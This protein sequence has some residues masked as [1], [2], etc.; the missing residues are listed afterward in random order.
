MEK[1]F[2]EQ[3]KSEKVNK[4]KDTAALQRKKIQNL[5]RDDLI[6]MNNNSQSD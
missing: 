3:E 5:K 6:K 4:F 1:E 2:E